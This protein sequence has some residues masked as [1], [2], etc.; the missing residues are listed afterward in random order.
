MLNWSYWINFQNAFI[1]NCVCYQHWQ[2]KCPS[3]L[4]FI[5]Q[6]VEVH[7]HIPLSLH[8]Q[9][10]RMESKM[11]NMSQCITPEL[12]QP[13]G[14]QT[15]VK[16]FSKIDVKSIV[17]HL[18]VTNASI[19]TPRVKLCLVF[20]SIHYDYQT[21]FN[22][23]HTELVK[24]VVSHA[25]AALVVTTAERFARQCKNTTDFWQ[26]LFVF[27]W[28]L[29][30]QGIWIRHI[31]PKFKEKSEISMEWVNNITELYRRVPLLPVVWQA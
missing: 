26:G 31:T 29:F 20:T 2:K 3:N 15:S 12:L 24:P 28:K 4:W 21:M 30:S 25:V 27:E 13:D 14:A 1:T 9:T 10:K 8:F 7:V 23:F 16:N 11:I 17:K 18:M 5:N 19:S 22:S 6:H